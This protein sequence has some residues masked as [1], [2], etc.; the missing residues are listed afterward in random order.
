MCREKGLDILVEAYIQ[1]HQR[2]R[3]KNLRLCVAGSLGSADQP[4]VNKLQAQ[5]RAAGLS[6]QARF[7]PNVD[8]LTKVALLQSLSVFSVPARYGEGFG[9]YVL[10]AL[11]AGTPVVQ[12][13]CAAFPELLELTGGGVLC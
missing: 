1:L 4:F 6:G 3:V 9:L 10:E 13:R 7:L 12:P 8:R 5:L 11:A 2:A